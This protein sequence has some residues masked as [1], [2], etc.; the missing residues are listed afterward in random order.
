MSVAAKSSDNPQNL[1]Q[2]PHVFCFTRD[3]SMVQPE[4]IALHRVMVVT[5]GNKLLLCRRGTIGKYSSKTDPGPTAINLYTFH[6]NEKRPKIRH[7]EITI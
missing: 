2:R 3:L 7:R 5:H 6:N 4:H 1:A